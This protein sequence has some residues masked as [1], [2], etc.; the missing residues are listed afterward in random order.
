MPKTAVAPKR[1]PKRPLDLNPERAQRVGRPPYAIVDIGSNSVRLVVY[2]QLG[3]AP[4]PRFN[5]KSLCRLGEKLAETGAIQPDN[6]RR[7]VEAA[8]RFRAIADA[9]GVTKIDATG[10]EAIRRATNGPEL[11]AAIR[12][13]SGLEVRIL[14]GA[15]EARY[16]ALGVVSGFFRPVGSVGDMGGGSL[17]VSEALDDKVGERWVSL[18][19]GALPVE[20]M[21]VDGLPAA[22]RRIDDMLR[23]SLPP[24]LG[25]KAFYPVGGGWRALAKA[26]MAAVGWPVQ[27]RARL[28]RRDAR[29]RANSPRRCRAS[30]RPSS[31]RRRA[32]PS[33]EPVRS[34]GRR[35]CSTG[36]SS[37]SQPERVVFSA[38]GLREGLLYSEP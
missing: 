37:A 15:E 28:Y 10:T 17:E 1:E 24:A 29:R 38:L 2:D 7:T 8:R 16:G 30:R 32:C 31:P 6:F 11:A 34:Q 36:C 9:M 27:G 14:S 18:P 12:K 13:E 20:A 4:M 21:L 26:H 33:A 22:K 35:C 5:E 3:R 23:E 19:L 25:H